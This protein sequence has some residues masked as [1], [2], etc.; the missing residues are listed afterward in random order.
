MK[1][2]E[3]LNE[4]YEGKS[5]DG[6]TVTK[7]KQYFTF[8]DAESYVII[9]GRVSK[10]HKTVTIHDKFRQNDELYNRPSTNPLTLTIHNKKTNFMSGDTNVPLSDG[11]AK[12]II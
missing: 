5:E 4:P 6:I 11:V 12:F 10:I 9:K 7:S 3:V 1:R 2:C 8:Q